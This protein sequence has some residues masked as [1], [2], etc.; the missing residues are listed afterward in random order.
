MFRNFLRERTVSSEPT[1]FAARVAEG[2][3]GRGFTLRQ[4]CRAVE[5]DPS[6]FSKVLSGKRSPPASE[7]VLR[8]IAKFLSLDAAELIVAAGRIPSEWNALWSDPALF[9]DMHGLATR[10]PAPKTR[11]AAAPLPRMLVMAARS[12]L[13]EELL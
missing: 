1:P 11:R 4:F 13:A 12:E 3:R 6:F 10:A 8:R 5:L 9:A 7:E 2:M